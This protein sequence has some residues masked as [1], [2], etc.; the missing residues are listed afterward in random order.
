MFGF[1]FGALC[2][3]GMVY[4]L[5]RPYAF[6]HGGGWHRGWYGHGRHGRGFDDPSWGD[7]GG[8]GF[9]VP[10]RARPMLRRVYERLGTSPAQE[11][12]L[13]DA[14]EAVTGAAAGL[15]SE[16]EQTRGDL[17]RALRA[18]PFDGEALRS[19]FARHDER[20]KA[21]RDVLLTQGTR[22][23]EV[24]DGRQR[25]SLADLLEQGPGRGRWN[26]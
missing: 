23:H 3:A 9:G 13:A 26:V 4:V 15:R 25:A 17:G 1:F 11:T 5:R 24:L 18:E 6:A 7:R 16:W 14:V 19:A 20:I 12:V 22:I 2:L 10:G 21:L 8:P